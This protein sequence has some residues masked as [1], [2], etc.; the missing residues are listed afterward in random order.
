MKK[1]SFKF[2]LA[3]LLIGMTLASISCKKS[4]NVN[5][6]GDSYVQFKL[7]GVQKK[8]TV[9]KILNNHIADGYFDMICSQT[10]DTAVNS[11]EL[12]I[13]S[14]SPIDNETYNFPYTY[15]RYKDGAGKLYYSNGAVTNT[16]TPTS[17]SSSR[18]QGTFTGGIT[19]GAGHNQTLTDGAF[20]ITLN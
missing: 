16:L 17:I 19:D 4:N 14:D 3:F 13:I 2:I 9:S 1:I 12:K 18:I 20:D 8:F 15:V 5:P 6:S 7:D 10:S 11:L